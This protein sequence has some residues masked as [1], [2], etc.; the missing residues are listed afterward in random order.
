[1]DFFKLLKAT[2]LVRNAQEE[3]MPKLKSSA[4]ELTAMDPSKLGLPKL[5]FQKDNPRLNYKKAWQPQK[6]H[7]ID[8][9][10]ELCSTEGDKDKKNKQEE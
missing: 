1:M 3:N 2:G 5:D 8:E 10:F 6:V 4:A 9:D 7:K